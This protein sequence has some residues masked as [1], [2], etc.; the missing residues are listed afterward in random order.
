VSISIERHLN[1][2]LMSAILPQ[3]TQAE[4]DRVMR[5]YLNAALELS[6]FT[7]PTHHDRYK[8]FDAEAL[9]FRN[10]GD[11]HQFLRRYLALKIS[12]VR[13]YLKKDVTHLAA[14]IETLNSILAQPYSGGYHLIHGDYYPGNILVDPAHRVT[15]LLDFGLLTMYGDPL[16]DLATGWVFFDMYDELKINLCQRYLAMMLET[17]GEDIRGRLYRYV[18]L[19]SFL[20]A[21]FYSPDCADGHYEWCVANLNHA[22]Y[23]NR[24]E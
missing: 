16:F 9:S 5:I 6:N 22:D 21:N 20:S 2:M 17:L 24:I 8:L 3:L 14:K 23:W 11:W 7:L 1:G 10:G 15:A 19:Y 12:Q 13:P 18:L 4:T